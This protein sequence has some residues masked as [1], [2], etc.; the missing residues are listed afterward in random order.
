MSNIQK[1]LKFQLFEKLST[2]L[3]SGVISHPAFLAGLI[4]VYGW[5]P[6][7]APY[8][9]VYI[10]RFANHMTGYFPATLLGIIKLVQ[11]NDF[12]TS[13]RL[14]NR[15]LALSFL[16]LHSSSQPIN[17]WITAASCHKNTPFCPAPNL[18]WNKKSEQIPWLSS[19]K[20][21][22]DYRQQNFPDL[23]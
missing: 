16:V 14:F 2:K 19:A 15:L 6:V 17:Q 20:Q 11:I 13:L 23:F 7:P 4:A 9:C 8:R 3:S 5:C 10:E 21:V 22:F 12:A 18:A 1:Q